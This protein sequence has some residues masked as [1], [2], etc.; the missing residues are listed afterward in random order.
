MD[1]LIS[2]FLAETTDNLLVLDND[3]LTLEQDPNN[4]A[5][6]GGI[7]RVM[8]T[9]KGTCGFLGLSRLEKVAH[10]S[11]NVLDNVRN[12]KLVADTGVISV[13]LESIDQIKSL[14]SHLGEHGTEPAGEDGVL[15]A[16][17]NDCAE[18]KMG[19]APAPAAAASATVAPVAKTPDLDQEID[20]QPIPAPWLPQAAAPAETSAVVPPPKVEEAPKI[21][22]SAKAAAITKG[23]EAAHDDG[24]GKGAANVAAQQGIRVSLQVLEELMQMASEL[25][26]TRNQ[27]LQ[28]ARHNTNAA[29][30]TP[31][32]RL[33]HITSDLH[34]G[35]MKTRMQPISTAW[36]KFPRLIRDLAHELN[37]KIDLR[38]EGAETELDRQ[39]LEVIKDPLTHMVRN[40][41]D[42]GIEVPEVRKAAGKPEMGTI[43]LNAF[44]E[45][46]HIIIKISDDGKGINLN[47]VKKKAVERKLASQAEVDAMAP[48]QIF[49]FIFQAGFSTAEKITAV[50]GRGVGMDVVMTN[51][52]KIGGSLELDSVEGQG[53]IFTI[54]IPLTLAIM[55]VLIV[56]VAKERF[57]IPQIRVSEI[58]RGFNPH[59]AKTAKK[60]DAE[61]DPATEEGNIIESI[62]NA[63][64]L[65][66]RGSLLPLAL[67]R[68]MLS[69]KTTS[70]PEKMLRDSEFIVVCEHGSHRFGL[71]VD[72]VFDTE[73]IVVKPVSP[74]LKGV[75]VYSGMTILGDGSVVM[76]LDP[77]G[78][79]SRLGDANAP[80]K[81]RDKV[82]MAALSGEKKVPF[83]L[84][85]AGD[86]SKKAVPLELISR[87]EEVDASKTEWAGNKCVIQ[88]RGD[89]MHLVPAS[90]NITIP[91]KGMVP[92]IV[93]ADG[94]KVMG[95]VVDEILDIVEED[96]QVK[97]MATG[98][99]LLGSMVIAGETCDLVDI[100]YYFTKTF[101]DWLVAKGNFSGDEEQV[102]RT[103]GGK[104]LLLVD[105]SPFFR[106]FMKPILVVEGYDVITAED[107]MEALDLLKR[108][109][110]FDAIITD[111]DM[112]GMNGID[113]AKKCK[114]DQKLSALPI[115]A[116]TSYTS[117]KI[118]ESERVAAGFAGFVSKSDRN[119]LVNAITSILSGA[120]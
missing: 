70:E 15:I 32:Q 117:D 87:L 89:L 52:E 111:I 99:G 51:I 19:A 90:A 110:Q 58:V 36:A 108:E 34:E 17:L 72:Q 116:L 2:E 3:I 59:A 78:I 41:A 107:A 5:V 6:I 97:S 103:K 104:N 80:K 91:N 44:H 84:F 4:Q 63:L 60:K 94:D 67:M 86:R 42:H 92:I 66:L 61:E 40:S 57:A 75:N 48:K 33:S 105:D 43:T 79:A 46:G 109:Q 62:N 81:H 102:V 20:F 113:F 10:A 39:L 28:V 98:D 53:S 114:G 12:G 23:L 37:K 45:G 30:N 100:S 64:V 68:D 77:N 25:V 35:V 49:Q 13:I 95:L 18:G 73:E 14:V 47:A 29:F 85:R 22:E 96:M 16:R 106:K 69:G 71:V 112:P 88:Y 38:M 27:L 65:R 118:P 115:I 119:K 50:S 76:I 31:L 9:I 26:L 54:K 55:S 82:D 24:H 93:F 83:M 8:H 1:D 21:S 11:E 7:F 120:A 56:D 74:P 101:S